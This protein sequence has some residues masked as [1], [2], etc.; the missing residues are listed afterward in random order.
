[1][2]ESLLPTQYILL[3]GASGKIGLEIRKALHALAPGSSIICCSRSPWTGPQYPMEKWIVFNPLTDT[4]AWT[5]GHPIDVVVNAIGIIQES[6]GMTYEKV[7]VGIT[8]AILRNRAALGQPRIVQVSA[9]GASETHET[10]FLRTKGQADAKLLREVNVSILRPSIVCTP[11]TMLSQKLRQLLKIARFSLGKMLVPTGFPA[12]QI[13]PILGADVGFAVALAALQPDSPSLIE[14]VGPQR[15]SFGEL[16]AEMA[17]AQGRELRLLEV[18]REIMETFVKHFVGVWFPEL[19]N[20][21]Q[22][23]LLFVDNVGEVEQTAKLLGR[24]PQDTLPF[25]R[26][27]AQPLTEEEEFKEIVELSMVD[28]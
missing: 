28:K 9:L 1:M 25:W 16:I 14:L 7:H 13:Q 8:E 22:F 26:G 6:K 11:D 21:Q 27:E 23:R 12:T 20:Y 24:A 5:F 15:I 10:D 17:A 3:L 19:I 18:S 4:D 2:S